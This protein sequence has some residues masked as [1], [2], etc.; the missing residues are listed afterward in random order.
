MQPYYASVGKISFLVATGEAERSSVEKTTLSSRGVASISP[1]LEGTVTREVVRSGPDLTSAVGVLQQLS[2][3]VRAVEPHLIDPA[4]PTLGYAD[5]FELVGEARYGLLRRDSGSDG[6]LVA[7]WFLE[8][9]M[10]ELGVASWVVLTGSREHLREQWNGTDMVNRSGSGT[11]TIFD[12]LKATA[13][14]VVTASDP[15]PRNFFSAVSHMWGMTSSAH[16]IRTIA[17]VKHVKETLDGGYTTHG[18]ERLPVVRVIVASPLFVEQHR[19]RV[20]EPA[21]AGETPK[22]TSAGRWTRVRAW[23]GFR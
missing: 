8:V 17:E 21:Q 7:T 12:I 6:T 5:W 14:E 16:R 9:P 20:L 3:A 4:D 1:S 18:E 23:L 22:D 19:D 10:T 11:D 13:E 2:A 15:D